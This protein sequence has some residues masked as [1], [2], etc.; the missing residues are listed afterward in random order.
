MIVTYDRHLRSSLTIVTYDRKNIFIIQATG[1]KVVEHTT[2]ILKME[3][4]Y[5]TAITGREKIVKRPLLALL[6]ELRSFPV[7]SGVL[8]SSLVAKLRRMAEL[9]ET[10]AT[11]FVVQQQQTVVINILSDCMNTKMEVD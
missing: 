7:Y 4:S 5:P 2:H 11:D 6:V 9:I 10:H 1:S 8:E 3:G